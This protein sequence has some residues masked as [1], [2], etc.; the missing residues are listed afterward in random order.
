MIL[1]AKGDVKMALASIRTTRWRSLM[2]MMGIIIGVCSVV[3]IVS[4]GEGV[5][6]Q[7]VGQT[8]A[9]GS[10]LITVRPG[11]IN[12]QTDVSSLIS[13]SPFSAD[14]SGSLTPHDVG[15]ITSI[16]HVKTTVPLSIVPGGVTVGGKEYSDGVV[17][18]STSGIPQVLNQSLLYGVFF[19]A[20]Q[21]NSNVVVLGQTISNEL[22]PGQEPLGRSITFRGQNFIVYGEFNQ[23]DNTPF[24]LD[25]NF[26][27]AIFI[28][29]PVAQKLENNSAP[30]YEILAKPDQSSQLNNVVNT[31]QGK[32]LQARGGSRDF[33]VLKQ[34]Q[35]LAI[36]DNIVSLLS[37]L[38]G[39][40]AGI[41]LVVGGIGIMNVMLV[42]VT[43][44]TYEIGIRK[45]IGATNRQIMGQFLTES[46]IISL[47]GGLIGIIGSLII[48]ITL[49][50][51]TS[52]QPLVSWRVTV[53]AV[54]VSILVGIIFGIMP[55]YK[56]A[57]KDPIDSLRYQ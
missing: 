17:I 7:I 10:D 35:A 31:I 3:T 55:A 41:S 33:S 1:I 26:N 42:A 51:L 21:Q 44:R 20:S 45:A 50:I 28:P 36:S 43:E 46:I 14:S 18:G 56:A 30:I 27:N 47:V 5:K 4:I 57:H 52:L 2:T 22:F 34:S 29:Y 23:F 8:N 37:R 11:L 48:N 16:P 53:L 15:L 12:T 25:T 40:I 49:R 32:L 39:A 13:L 24:S 9:L 6:H 19:N 38:I 54:G